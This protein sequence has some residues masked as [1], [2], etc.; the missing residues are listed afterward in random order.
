MT[1]IITQ[2]GKFVAFAIFAIA[3]SVSGLG[4]T[5]L[6]EDTPATPSKERASISP[7]GVSHAMAAQGKA[8]P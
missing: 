4:T 6:A 8:A 2:I 3:S 7:L 5:A 1:Q